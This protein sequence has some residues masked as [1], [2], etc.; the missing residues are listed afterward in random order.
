MYV[1]VQ[2]KGVEE[3]LKKFDAK[4]VGKGIQ[5]ALNRSVKS[6]KTE[7][8]SQLRERWNLRKYDIDRKI[9]F[10]PA[11]SA[12]S[13]IAVIS[14]VG[15][16]T[17]LMHF[18]PRSASGG[19]TTYAARNRIGSRVMPGLAQKR[20]GRNTGGV[21]VAALRGR[22]TTLKRA[23]FTV[24]TKGGTPLVVWRSKEK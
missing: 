5:A 3:L 6:G 1:N 18:N 2:V 24:A 19:I 13:L 12:A 9:F 14:V 4:K 15:E 22:Q 20:G 11:Q 16:P 8:S 10:R 23:F 21:K 7:T 17:S